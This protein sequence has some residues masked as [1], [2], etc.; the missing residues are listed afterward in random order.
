MPEPKH[1]SLLYGSINLIGALLCGY[2]LLVLLPS[3][4]AGWPFV[5]SAVVIVLALGGVGMLVNRSWGRLL[6]TCSAVVLLA[7]CVT[8]VVLLV[9]SA[10]YLHA[11][12]GGVG[13]AGAALA[14]IAAALVFELT[15]IVPLLQLAHLRRTR[16]SRW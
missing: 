3:R 1:T 13:Q 15:G 4:W 5:A 9:A 12:Y 8:L 16:R 14:I 10:A 2:G 6:A 7:T 11:I